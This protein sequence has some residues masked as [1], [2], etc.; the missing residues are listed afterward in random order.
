MVYVGGA[1]LGHIAS[2]LQLYQ[3]TPNYFP[4][5]KLVAST[6]AMCIS[7][8][9]VS[10][11]R[12]LYQQLMFAFLKIINTVSHCGLK[13]SLICISGILNGIEH[14]V[15]CLLAISLPSFEKC[16]FAHVCSID[17]FF[18]MICSFLMS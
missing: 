15:I 18:S 5:C 13:C 8:S 11:V 2:H 7:N 17:L 9:S 3:M 6:I 10:V 16:L 12:Y 1:W 14:Y 4:R